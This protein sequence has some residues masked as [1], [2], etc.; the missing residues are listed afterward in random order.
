MKMNIIEVK[1]W[2]IFYSKTTL[3]LSEMNLTLSHFSILFLSVSGIL[4][5]R[6]ASKLKNSI[7]LK[8]I[9]IHE[10]GIGHTITFH[11]SEQNFDLFADLRHFVFFFIFRYTFLCQIIT[12]KYILRNTDLDWWKIHIC[13]DIE[14]LADNEPGTF[15]C[16]DFPVLDEV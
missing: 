10:D 3:S 8:G 13:A 11:Y 5:A 4:P 7:P 12:V 16:I 14:S 6:V 2:F 15:E 9:V 1:N